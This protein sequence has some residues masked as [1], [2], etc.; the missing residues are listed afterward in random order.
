MFAQRG[1]DSASLRTLGEAIGVSHAALRH[2][3]SSRDELLVEVYRTHEA[4]IVG[5]TV[6]EGKSAVGAIVMVAER[7]RSIPGLVSSTRPSPPVRCRNGA[8]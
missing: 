1:V 3:F 6:L 2:Y 5:G 8:P 7:T 4:L